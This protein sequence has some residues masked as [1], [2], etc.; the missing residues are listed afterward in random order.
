MDKKKL[1][2]ITPHCSTG[3]L[4]QFTL[5]K[6]KILKDEFDILCVEY[7]LLSPHFVV[8]RDQVIDIL[9][10]KFIS[11]GEDKFTLLQIIADFKPDYI[12]MEEFP[13]LFMNNILTSQIYS[14][15]REYIIFETTHSSNLTQKKFLPDKF[16]FVSKWSERMYSNLGVDYKIIEYPIDKKVKDTTSK[17]RLKLDPEYKHVLNVGLFTEGK[18][19]GYIFEIARKL[20]NEKIMFHFVGNMAQNF[21]SYWGPI[22]KNKPDN[23][24]IWGER[25][26]VDTF[27]MA[28]DAFLFTSK[29]ELNPLV[30]KEAIEYD[31][32]TL[33]F[34]LETYCN[35]YDDVETIKFLNGD[36][37]KDSNSLLKIL[38]IAYTSTHN[39][40]EEFDWGWL[41]DDNQKDQI[42]KEI[43]EDKI[44]EKL[45]KVEE[46]D[47]VMDIGSSVGP[48]TRSILHRKPKHV[49]CIEPSYIEFET[50]LKNTS[51][52]PVTCISKGICNSNSIVE[53]PI[54]GNQAFMDGI[55]FKT[56]HQ[57]YN[58]NNID[59]LKVDCEGG[60]YDIFIEDNI[61]YLRNIKKIVGEWHLGN[62]MLKDKFIKFRDNVLSKFEN[63]NVLSLDLVNIKWDLYNTHFVDRYT[64][65]IIYIENGK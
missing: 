52:Y 12:F 28:S 7:T 6:I 2:T 25:G 37:E 39:E 24:I 64:E 53:I 61:E 23:C 49:Y 32:P 41:N 55:T 1:L 27:L 46:G 33:M 4:P 10:D 18:N 20:Q 30:I 16:I 44:Y 5:S 65:I 54:Y 17:I 58:I 22:M 35:C 26:D 62:K 40:L 19:Q 29:F 34:N 51:G 50:L 43:F 60:E 48:F 36:I 8:Q 15:N 56:L 11:L 42:I 3:G 21:E 63:Y 14:P 47:V 13:E 9:G 31:L 45:F 59:F 57:T 38:G